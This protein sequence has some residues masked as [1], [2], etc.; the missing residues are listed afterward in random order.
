MPPWSTG[1]IQVHLQIEA[2]EIADIIGGHNQKPAFALT[3]HDIPDDSHPVGVKV[4]HWFIQ[5]L[6]GR[7]VNQ[8][9]CIFGAL[10]HAG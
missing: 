9:Q 3:L 4:G 8:S 10:L 7:T 2:V 1:V 6:H 5:D